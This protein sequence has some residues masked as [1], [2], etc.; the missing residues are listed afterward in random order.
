[1]KSGRNRLESRFE[2]ELIFG[3][4]KCLQKNEQNEHIGCKN[5]ENWLKQ[6]KFK[7]KFSIFSKIL[8][9]IEEKKIINFFE[10]FEKILKM[11]NFFFDKVE[12]LHL[13]ATRTTEKA[14]C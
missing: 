7:K 9:F 12:I 8:F 13:F 3:T 5:H 14:M 2:I 10:T 6:F 4:K 11:L 1:M